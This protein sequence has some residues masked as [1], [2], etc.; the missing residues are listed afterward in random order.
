M[1]V[2][3]L[4]PELQGKAI[5]DGPLPFLFGSDA[6]QLKKRYFLRIVTPRDVQGHQIW[7]EAY[8]RFQQDAANFHHAQFII[9][10][11][12]MTPFA[13][14]LIQPDTK[15]FIVYQFFEIVMNDPMRMFR[16]DPF[17]AVRPL[18]WQSL[19]EEPQGEQARRPPNDSRR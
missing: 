13:L 19:V 7:L 10:T 17:R 5:A 9:G 16:G 6:Q 4:P 2:H 18:G 8:P 11:E 1:I 14:K 12:G 15:N 3:K